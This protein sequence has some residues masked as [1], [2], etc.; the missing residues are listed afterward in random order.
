MEKKNKQTPVPV[1]RV[2]R[3]LEFSS[4]TLGI[5]RNV[6]SSA[7]VE[8]FKG[9]KPN[10]KELIQSDQNIRKFVESVSKMRGAALKIGQLISLEG[11]DF[12]PEEAVNTLSLLRK[13]ADIMPPKQLKS[14][15]SNS[16]G[17]KFLKKFNYFDVNPIASASIGQVH[18]AE[19]KKGK[20]IVIK[21][22]YPGVKKSIKSDISNLSLLLKT[23]KIVPPQIDLDKLMKSAQK[24]LEQE[25]DY[26]RESNYQKK[27]ID[28]IRTE[29]KFKIPNIYDEFTT[30]TSISMDFIEGEPI[31]YSKSKNQKIKNQIIYD[32]LYLF[33]KEI[34]DFN[35][36]QTDPNFA[37]FYIEKNTDKIVLLDFG[38][39]TKI[40]KDTSKKFLN[41]L[42]SILQKKSNQT[43]E[44]LRDLKIIGNDDNAF[45]QA[46][47]STLYEITS[48]LRKNEE[49]D[50]NSLIIQ[51][52]INE[53]K[54]LIENSKEK[55]TLPDF[56][57]LLIQRKIGGLFLLAKQFDA[58]LNLNSIFEKY[59]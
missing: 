18:F 45:S 51:N 12:L 39:T 50:F 53:I 59:I 32:L 52:S 13:D 16:I 44:C 55:L 23:S 11:S 47:V 57:T 34:F 2:S 46:I 26:L 1:G 31:N 54:F 6:I 15:L 22:Q 9:N 35:L 7:T 43:K 14:V 10:F 19:T 40:N 58:K 5:T 25:T 38:A 42:K 24:Q 33:F 49:F 21:I 3:F 37:N 30:E 28:L 8:Y 36:M 4:M 56:E 20:K 27:F 29:K 41:L 17:D 48:P